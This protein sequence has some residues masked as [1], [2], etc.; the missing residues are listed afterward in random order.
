MSIGKKELNQMAL[1]GIAAERARLEAMERE[2]YAELE[3]MIVPG[4]TAVPDKRVERSTPIVSAPSPRKRVLSAAGRA[5][6]G[7][8]AR[9]RWAKARKAQKAA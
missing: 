6:I 5:A 8:A 9:K 7:A 2:I 3:A 1:R 4:P